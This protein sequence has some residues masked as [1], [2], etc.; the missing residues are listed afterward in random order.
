MDIT[1][2]T[3]LEIMKAFADKSLPMPSIARTMPM[4][5]DTIT[6]GEVVFIV[7]A[8]NNHINPLGSIHGGFSA[9]II[10]SVTGC[11]LHTVLEAGAAYSTIDLNVKMCMPIPINTSLKAIGKVI[12]VTN[13]LGISEG[14]IVDENGTVYAYGTALLKL[15]RKKA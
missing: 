10:D 14:K 15:H 11:A 13:S 4:E 9:T 8:N 3:G 12:N 2:M 5:I 6:K 1:K 7:M